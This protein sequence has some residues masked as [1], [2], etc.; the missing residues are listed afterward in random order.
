M[1]PLSSVTID[2]CCS[3]SP[4]QTSFQQFHG[5]NKH[6]I[7]IYRPNALGGRQSFRITNQ[8]K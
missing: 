5:V 4:S 6:G 2:A 1:Q 8:L 7:L 3:N